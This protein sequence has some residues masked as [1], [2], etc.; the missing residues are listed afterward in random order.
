MI[1]AD[2][3]PW[4]GT[5]LF[6]LAGVILGAVATVFVDYQRGQREE[7]QRWDKERREL[8]GRYLAST[9]D[10]A[11]HWADPDGNRREI[12]KNVFLTLMEIEFLSPDT[13]SKAAWRL[14]DACDTGAEFDEDAMGIYDMRRVQLIAAIRD[15]LGIALGG[16]PTSSEIESM[17]RH[18][19]M[20]GDLS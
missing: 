14:F 18:P 17:N 6:T 15:L 13:V 4:W 20:G 12:A 16:M 5:A 9:Y 8:Y 1:L 7:R 19:S 11:H 2:G 10:L 3:A